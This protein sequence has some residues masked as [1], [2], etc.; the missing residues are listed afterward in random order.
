ML[1]NTIVIA[2]T[3]KTTKS[4]FLENNEVIFLTGIKG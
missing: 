1:D 3:P 4:Y 2:G